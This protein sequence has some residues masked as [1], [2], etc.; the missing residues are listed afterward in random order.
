MAG[1]TICVGSYVRCEGRKLI[2]VMQHHRVIGYVKPSALDEMMKPAG[3]TQANKNVSNLKMTPY[4][5][6]IKKA[7]E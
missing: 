7:R 1:K 3:R 4:K 6:W 2:P 5:T